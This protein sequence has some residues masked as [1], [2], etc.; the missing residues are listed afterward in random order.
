MFVLD[1]PRDAFFVL[2]SDRNILDYAAITKFSKDSSEYYISHG[3][4]KSNTYMYE[5]NFFVFL[6]FVVLHEL[7]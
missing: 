6:V 2:L 5:T 4:L 1:R 7:L 3:N